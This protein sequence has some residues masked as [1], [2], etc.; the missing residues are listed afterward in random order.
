MASAYI[1]IEYLGATA[2]AQKLDQVTAME[3]WSAGITA[4]SQTYPE[5]RFVMDPIRF[6]KEHGVYLGVPSVMMNSDNV[7]KKKITDFEKQQAEM[8][9]AMMLLQTTL[10]VQQQLAVEG[11]EVKVSRILERIYDNAGWK[12]YATIVTDAEQAGQEEGQAE[13]AGA[14]RPGRP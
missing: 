9:K 5:V 8:Q 12:D 11:K 6:T 14:A 7:I 13:G 1:D 3:R 10:S 2:R 4:N